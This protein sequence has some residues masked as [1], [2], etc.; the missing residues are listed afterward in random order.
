MGGEQSRRPRKPWPLTLSR[1]APTP[2]IASSSGAKNN[3]LRQWRVVVV[4]GARRRFPRESKAAPRMPEFLEHSANEC[5][6]V[7][8]I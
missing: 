2:K 1:S 4:V 8:D 7:F 5:G 3:T 6:F